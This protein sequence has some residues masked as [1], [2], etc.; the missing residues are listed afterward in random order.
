MNLSPSE[1]EE[2]T[3]FTPDILR[4][5]RRR[6]FLKRIG[7]I[8]LPD[9][10]VTSDVERARE[11][12]IA[13]PAWQYALGDAVLLSLAR[14]F[15]DLTIDIETQ[16]TIAEFAAPHVV[17]FAMK[18]ELVP[19]LIDRRFLAVWRGVDGAI[20]AMRFNDLNR[21]V[22]H[23]ITRAI[24]IDMHR[25]ASHLPEK[26]IHLLASKFGQVEKDRE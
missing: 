7:Q 13:R 17:E 1:I 2:V 3:G 23:S 20:Q 6:G 21:L 24:V 9:G 5:W 14:S 26:L 10:S 12:G 16:L 11:A 22:D 25:E 19:S 15:S 18:S 4:D 8:A